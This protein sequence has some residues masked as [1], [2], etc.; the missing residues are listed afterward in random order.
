MDRL[1]F[2]VTVLKDRSAMATPDSPAIFRRVLSLCSGNYYR[3]RFCEEHFN[4]HAAAA[5]LAI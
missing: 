4:H 3:S 1:A 2:A 5:R